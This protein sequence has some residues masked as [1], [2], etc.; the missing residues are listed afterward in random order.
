[1]NEAGT[2]HTVSLKLL[3]LTVVAVFCGLILA[4]CRG[5]AI[6]D[7]SRNMEQGSWKSTDIVK[8]NVI[9]TDTAAAYNIYLN[10]R[11]SKDY[12][13]SNLYLFVKTFYPDGKISIDTVECFLADVEGRWMGKSAGRMVDNRM[14]F[15]KLVR[16]PQ[17]G[18]YSFEFEQAM[19]EESLGGMENFGLRIEKAEQ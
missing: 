6:F 7:E 1:M 16:F 18:Q 12:R 14:L 5:N 10:I 11:N 13:Y 15:R 4:G 3:K 9:I 2:M 17:S 19:R 8:F